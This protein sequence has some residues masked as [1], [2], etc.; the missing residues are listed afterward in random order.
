MKTPYKNIYSILRINRM[1][2]ILVVLVAFL[3]SGFSLWSVYQMNRTMLNSMFAVHTDG[4]V[5]PLRLVEEQE[6]LEVEA[7][8]HLELF[9]SYFYG[10]DISNY[11]AQLEK[12]LWLGNTSVDNVYQQ[13]KAEGI[14][15]RLLQYSLVQ[16]IQNIETELDLSQNAIGFRTTTIFD[17]SRGEVIDTYE[18]VTTGK[19][20][21]VDRHFPRNTHGFLIT[22]FF[23][24]SLKKQTDENQ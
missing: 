3:S 24:N 12:A 17:I 18:L 1:I 9:H 6:N 16:R 19:L 4:S 2:V 23:E 5:L 13:K 20:I 21:K 11:E 8:A 22:D 15:N 14:Y 10:I 7:K